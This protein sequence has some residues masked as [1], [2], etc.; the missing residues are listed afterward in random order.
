[1]RTQYRA[2]SLSK[3][4]NHKSKNTQSTTNFCLPFLLILLGLFNLGQVIFLRYFATHRLLRSGS[5][6]T[7][8]HY[9]LR[10][11]IL[12]IA[13]SVFLFLVFTRSSRNVVLLVLFGFF[14]VGD[15]FRR[16]LVAG[17]GCGLALL[18]G[19]RSLDWTLIRVD[20]W[21]ENAEDGWYL[22]Q[23]ALLLRL[24]P[25]RR[26]RRRRILHICE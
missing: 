21:E 3:P 12:L 26:H 4:S 14:F 1:M 7:H 5:R 16:F 24:H 15:F 22:H 6:S 13:L 11:Q 25:P 17:C 20:Q 19:R 8:L 10:L 2:T 18:R 23:R 9:S